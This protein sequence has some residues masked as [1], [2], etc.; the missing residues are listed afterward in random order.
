METYLNYPQ[1]KPIICLLNTG[2]LSSINE[3]SG[4]QNND[5]YSTKTKGMFIDMS[6]KKYLF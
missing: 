1:K 5:N 3:F 2:G 4:T 6:F